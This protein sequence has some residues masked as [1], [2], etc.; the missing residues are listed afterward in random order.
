MTKVTLSTGPGALKVKANA[1]C[2]KWTQAALAACN[3]PDQHG[4][5]N[6]ANG[7]IWR[8]NVNVCGDTFSFYSSL[9]SGTHKDEGLF[10]LNTPVSFN[11]NTYIC[12]ISRTKSCR[13]CILTSLMTQH[14]SSFWNVICFHFVKGLNIWRIY[15]FEKIHENFVWRLWIFLCTYR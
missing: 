11:P 15:I 14:N 8:A 3:Q 2:F 6:S 5:Y 12:Y 7:Y 4:V 10:N 13:G 1:P 9:T